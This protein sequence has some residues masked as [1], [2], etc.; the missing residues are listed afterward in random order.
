MGDDAGMPALQALIRTRGLARASLLLLATLAIA[1]A[2]ARGKDHPPPEDPLAK[3]PAS[4]ITD[5]FAFRV[6]YFHGSV[7]TTGHVDDPNATTAGTPF[8]AENDLGLSPR[9]H[10]F[11]SELFFRLRS[12]SRLRVD[13][14]ELNREAIASPSFPIVYGGNTFQVT[15]KVRTRLDW[16]QVD[17]TYSYAL[18]RASRYELAAGLGIHLLQTDAEARVPERQIHEE[19][20]GSGP[21]PTVDLEGTVRLWQRWSF[22]ARAQYLSLT[23]SSVK[24]SLADYSGNLQYRLAPNF[25]LGLGY[26]SQQM[27]IQVS[28]NNP[29]GLLELKV[30]GPSL[31]LRASF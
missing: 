4:P 11:R 18:L 6:D 19:F 31:F 8:S 27:K 25:A 20:S 28:N 3:E 14:W 13:L 24:G 1:Q 29:N 7:T 26:R 17:L 10:E 30:N 15:D 22:E 12:R 5:H 21:F 16:R 2:G 9:D 23:V